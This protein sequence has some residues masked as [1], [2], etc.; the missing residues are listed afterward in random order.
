M[1]FQVA[2]KQERAKTAQNPTVQKETPLNTTQGK[3][4]Y[5]KGGSPE[6]Q[7]KVHYAW[8]ISKDPDFVYLLEAENGLWTHTRRHDPENNVVGVDWGLCGTNDYWHPQR[9]ND[10]RFMTD[11]KWQVREC[12]TMY[13]GGTTFYGNIP[14]AKHNFEWKNS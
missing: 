3:K 2:P 5:K 7:E 1:V 8:E 14:K 10:P 4:P 9:V 12:L 13:N 6:Q 11:W